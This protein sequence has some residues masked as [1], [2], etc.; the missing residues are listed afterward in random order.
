VLGLHRG[1]TVEEIKARFRELAL[2]HHPDRGGDAAAF[3]R[4]KD[5]Y[6]SALRDQAG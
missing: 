1:A 5:A 3:Q 4:V 6:D 2:Q